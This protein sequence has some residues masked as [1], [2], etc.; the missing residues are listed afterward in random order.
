MN[1]LLKLPFL[2][3]V[4]G[5]CAA[6]ADASAQNKPATTMYKCKDEKGR[7]YYSDKYGP[8]C[9]QGEV[10]QLSRQGIKV[11]RANSSSHSAM[12]SA[13]STPVN[14]EQKRR[15]KA[16]LATYSSEAQIEDA[17]ERNV[18]LPLQAAKQAEAKLERV[19]KDLQGLHSQAEGYASQKKQIPAQLIE[20]VRDKQMQ[21]AK[22]T[23][24]AERKR[25]NVKQIEE[26]F[27]AD[28]KRY[29]E[30]SLQQAAR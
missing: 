25:S 20:D 10:Q 26:R 23:V 22:L 30:L 27:D 16:L 13:P 12:K 15:D 4:A 8:E 9:A 21:V 1:D 18:A 17:K 24:D 28:K 19:Q 14:I 6:V 29:R 3:L 7:T 11:S 2:L 5:L